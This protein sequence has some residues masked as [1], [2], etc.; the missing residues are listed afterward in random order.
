MQNHQITFLFCHTEVQNQSY[1]PLVFAFGRYCYRHHRICAN[2]SIF[3][4]DQLASN[5]HTDVV[6]E[7]LKTKTK[8][9]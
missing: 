7:I 8:L 1:L 9:S 2:V 3:R 5:L 4:M 6:V